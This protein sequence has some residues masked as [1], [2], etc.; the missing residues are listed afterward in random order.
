MTVDGASGIPLPLT[1]NPAGIS[2]TLSFMGA[3]W[4]QPFQLPDGTEII[5]YRIWLI[6]NLK[7]GQRSGSAMLGKDGN[8]ILVTDNYDDASEEVKNI[9]K[10]VKEGE[11]WLKPM[12][13]LGLT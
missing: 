6:I 12:K 11:S 2:G 9:L 7:T 8:T 5:L 3:D 13:N 1:F 4:T 10:N